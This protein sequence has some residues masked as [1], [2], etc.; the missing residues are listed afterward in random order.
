MAY[1]GV[2][3]AELLF[4]FWVACS[5]TLQPPVCRPC[6]GLCRREHWGYRTDCLCAESLALGG[7][8]FEQTPLC[9]GTRDSARGAGWISLLRTHSTHGI[10][11]ALPVCQPV[12][13]A[14]GSLS[15]TPILVLGSPIFLVGRKLHSSLRRMLAVQPSLSQLGVQERRTGLCSPI[16]FTV[17]SSALLLSFLL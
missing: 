5:A 4:V 6:A 8:P 14:L 11:P 13:T 15:Y 10:A 3:R 9:A 1:F 7:H 17:T 2:A 12:P 16:F